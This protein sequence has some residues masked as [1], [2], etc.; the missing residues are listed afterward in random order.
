[1]I[2][3]TNTQRHAEPVK[4]AISILIVDDDRLM[5]NS[6]RDLLEVYDMNCTLAEDGQQALTH[7]SNNPFDWLC[8][9]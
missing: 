7:L 9:H 8:S 2:S 6:L 1:M 3:R 4:Q 5:R